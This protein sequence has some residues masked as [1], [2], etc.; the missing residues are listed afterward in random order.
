MLPV[1]RDD[2]ETKKEAAQRIPA[3]PTLVQQHRRNQGHGF[4]TCLKLAPL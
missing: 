1:L 3:A 4:A 2:T